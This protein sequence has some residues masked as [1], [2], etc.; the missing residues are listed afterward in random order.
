MCVCVCVCVPTIDSL[1]FFSALTSLALI[2]LNTACRVT[3]GFHKP[4]TFARI[5]LII[6]SSEKRQKC[7]FVFT[8]H[9]SQSLSSTEGAH[10]K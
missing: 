9:E 7:H 1:Q 5:H 6:N 4:S 8:F 3:T 2:L 10:R